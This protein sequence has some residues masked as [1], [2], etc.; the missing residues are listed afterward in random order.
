MRGF[1]TFIGSGGLL[2]PAAPT[3]LR[4]HLPGIHP[5]MAALALCAVRRDWPDGTHEFVGPDEDAPHSAR[6][7][8]REQRIWR[9]CPWRPRLSVVRLSLRD[10]DL[11]AI[12]RRHCMAPDCAVTSGVLV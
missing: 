2:W 4:A 5:D 10:F 12:G 11:H 3:E 6:R 8:E 1:M 9:W 7:L